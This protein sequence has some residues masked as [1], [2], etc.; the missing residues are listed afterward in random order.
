MK[1]VDHRPA[2][3]V[4]RAP[5]ACSGELAQQLDPALRYHARARVLADEQHAP[6]AAVGVVDRAVGVREVAR[7]RPLAEMEDELLVDRPAGLSALERRAQP[8]LEHVPR[9]GQHLP[10]RTPQRPRVELADGVA[11]RVVVQVDQL[12][13]PVD[14]HRKARVQTHRDAGA[15]A[16]RPILQRA[17]RCRRPV[18]AA[19]QARH[20]GRS[21]PCGAQNCA[22]HRGPL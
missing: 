19:H 18:E 21:Q 11:V 3:C 10:R 2:D 4:D 5:F 9:L 8:R 1:G 17:E 6:D 7:L 16:R 22:T 14:H 13:T 12:G 20:L 15:Q